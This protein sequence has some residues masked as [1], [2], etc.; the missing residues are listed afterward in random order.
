MAIPATPDTSKSVGATD[1]AS[2]GGL[3]NTGSEA[4]LSGINNSIAA[5]TE[6]AQ[7]AATAAGTS[8]TNAATSATNA[9]AS[10]STA[11][12]KAGEAAADAVDTAADAVSTA[13][14]RV[15]TGSDKT[16]S[17]TSAAAALVS[18]NA[19]AASAT[20]AAGSESSVATNAAAAATSATNAS[21]SASTASTQATNAG[22]SA[23]SATASK[24]AAAT[25][26]TN[27]ATSATSASNSVTAATTAKTAAETAKTGAETAETNASTSASTASTQATNASNSA[28][29]ASTQATNA[30]TSATA[31]ATSATASATSATA[32]ETA[33]TASETAKTAAEAAFDSFDDRYLGAKSSDP[34]V[35]NDGNALITGALYFNSTST[36]MKVYTGSAWNAAATPSASTVNPL[37]DAHLN[38]STASSGELLG[39]N[40]SDY[41]WIS[42]GGGGDLLA[43]NNLSD[44]ANAATARTNLGLAIGSNVQAYSSVLAGTTASY[45]TALNTKLSGIE[46]SA[47]VTDATNVASAGALM[48]SE[49]TNLAQVKAFNSSDYAT[50]AQGTLATNALPKSGGAMTGAITTNSTFDGRD[51]ATDGTK[52]DGI[53]ASA[54]VTDTANVVS[55]LTAGTGI[56]IAGNGTIAS[57]VT[58]TTSAS[59]LTSGTLPD[60]R[61][62]SALPA[63][64][65]AALTNLPAS[66]IASV[67]ADT[68]PQLGGNLDVVTHD[69]VSTSNRN[70][71]ILPNGSGKVNLD[72]NG[73]S[74]GVSVSDGLVDI[75]TGT[76]NRSQ[77]KFYCEVSNAHAQTIQ[78]QPHSAGVTNTLTLPAG[79]NQELVGTTATQTLTNKSIAASQLTGALP[80]ISGAALTN[81]PSSTDSTKMPLAGGTFSGN[82]SFPNNETGKLL[83]GGSNLQIGGNSS[84]YGN[85]NIIDSGLDLKFGMGSNKTWGIYRANMSDKIMEAI[86]GAGIHLYYNQSKKLEITNTG[87]TVTGTLAATA[88]TGNGS[89]L[90]NLP[91][92]ADLYAANESNP[93]AQPSATGTNAIAIGDQAV[94]SGTDSFAIGTDTDATGTSSLAIGKG[95]QA[96]ANHNLA[97]GLNASASAERAIAI[98]NNGVVAGSTYSTAIGHNSGTGGSVTATGSGATALGG[99]RA[100]GADSLAAAIANNTSSYGATDG[101]T[102]AMG[103]SAKASLYFATAIGGY[104]VASGGWSTAIGYASEATANF[105]MAL[106]GQGNIASAN[107]AIAMGDTS[108]ASHANAVSIGDSVQSTAANQI[109]LGGTA[110]T[111]RISETYTLPTSDGSN[112]QVLTTNG[113]GV[114]SFAAAGGGADLY[115]ANESSPAAQPSA[116]GT[117]AIAIG[118]S[119]VASGPDSIAIGKQSVTAVDRAFAIGYSR[120]GGDNALAVG[121]YN[122]TSSYGATG[123]QSF[124]QSDRAKASGQQSFS[125]GKQSIASGARAVALGRQAEASGISAT[126]I[127][128]LAI[129]QG[130]NNISIGK[131][132]TTPSSASNSVALGTNCR[133]NAKGKIAF[134]A[135]AGGIGLGFAQSGM[136]V[137]HGRTANAT[138]SVLTSDGGLQGVGTADDDNQLYVELF[139][140]I[141]FDG[142]IV[143]R[144]QG[145][146]SNTDCAA[147]KIEGLIRRESNVNTTVLVNSATTVI[148]NA[149]NWGVTLSADT[150]N[151][152][153]AVHV[154]GSSSANV[155][156]VC[157]LRTSETIYNSY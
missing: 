84:Y 47:D 6:A 66:G 43:A 106:G 125:A 133:T 48:D 72:G 121:I 89:G 145:N 142:L 58:T 5:N 11:S 16:A 155:K 131:E 41:D 114:V 42:A 117:N 40:G 134:G 107:H 80:A 115:A 154:T 62:P 130:T 53:E 128:Y 83:M 91:G 64:S 157:T 29:T 124:A 50:S 85:K 149:P 51:V 101:N 96:T 28:S 67:A 38:Q 127:G 75:R 15:Q 105:A 52:L 144:G 54:D 2:K 88:V 153:L 77:V 34:T 152:C 4:I 71:D 78:P 132:A 7:T 86:E 93:A 119:A 33:K 102:I 61:F 113:S 26:A 63:I 92:G 60:A 100:A 146:A 27:A 49:V 44:V 21:T 122:N 116:T 8:A 45:T 19:A 147:F 120:S 56:T 24:N 37:I 104:T 22:T 129:A 59:D 1:D 39:W 73:S 18:K 57:T 55:A 23:T 136:L 148:N 9:A 25:S 98:G 32:S 12:T 46:A 35:D 68:S 14:D 97:I 108:T 151:G 138:S 20:A 135:Q 65:G 141:A 150:T 31:A 70:I 36:T 17:N 76:G 140:A 126:A 109:N 143:A 111:V 95:A 3:L 79:G 99:S 103:S 74:G 81:L 82:V 69:I 123:D 110:D 90:T 118:N 94:S 139:G 87:A 156:W 112:G 137:I 30:S 10:A 13:A